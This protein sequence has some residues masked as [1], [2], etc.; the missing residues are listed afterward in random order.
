MQLAILATSQPA[1]QPFSIGVLAAEKQEWV[2]LAR[3][4]AFCH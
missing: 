4:M 1:N 2:G 3:A